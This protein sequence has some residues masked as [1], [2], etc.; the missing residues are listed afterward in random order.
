MIQIIAKRKKRITKEELKV[1]RTDIMQKN[2]LLKG[3]LNKDYKI[4]IIIKATKDVT[5]KGILGRMGKGKGKVI[6][7]EAVVL[8]GQRIIILKPKKR[9]N[10]LKTIPLI[11]KLIRKYTYMCSTTRR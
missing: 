8:K 4:L 10:L 3:Q 6:T 2:G 5:S 1:I 11:R 9:S 7:K